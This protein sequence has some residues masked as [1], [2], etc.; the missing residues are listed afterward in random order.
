MRVLI[1]REGDWLIAQAL[2]YD[3]TASAQSIEDLEYEFERTL[4]VHAMACSKENL[5]PFYSL[6]PAPDMFWKAF[7]CGREIKLHPP[8]IVDGSLVDRFLPKFSSKV[9][10]G[11]HLQLA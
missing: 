9:F 5:Q 6:N 8:R 11:R 3:L 7:E 1:Y 4:V 10:P 2:E